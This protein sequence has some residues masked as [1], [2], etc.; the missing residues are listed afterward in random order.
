MDTVQQFYGVQILQCSRYVLDWIRILS[1]VQTLAEKVTLAALKTNHVV[2]G[3]IE[4]HRQK[5]F[6][7]EQ[8]LNAFIQMNMTEFWVLVWYECIS[9]YDIGLV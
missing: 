7:Y 1:Q 9:R 4:M 8:S 6:H 2:C 3:H 5:H